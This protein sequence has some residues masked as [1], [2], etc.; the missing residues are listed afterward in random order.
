MA[1]R[2]G[3]AEDPEVI[4]RFE[5]ARWLLWSAPC[6]LRAAAD[7]VARFQ[8]ALRPA[9]KPADTYQDGQGA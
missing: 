4:E 5:K 7:A 2:L 9:T 1:A 3:V 8:Q 6:D